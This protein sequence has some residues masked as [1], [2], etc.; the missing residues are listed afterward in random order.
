MKRTFPYSP[1]ILI[2]WYNLVPKTDK[3]EDHSG[4]MGVFGTFYLTCAV[5]NGG[6]FVISCRE[7]HK[8]H[9]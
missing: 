7:R 9:F 4:R 6:R 2:I 5:T 8:F 3:Q 1:R